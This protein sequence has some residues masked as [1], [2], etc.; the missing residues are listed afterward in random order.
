VNAV[1]VVRGGGDYLSEYLTDLG[2]AE[3]FEDIQP[4][5]MPSPEGCNSVAQLQ[6]HADKNRQDTY[7]ANRRKLMLSESTLIKDHLEQAAQ[8][9]EVVANRSTFSPSG[10]HQRNGYSRR[11]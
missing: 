8:I 11:H 7:W 1:Y 10:A 2:P 6:E 5:I 3:N 9:R 4:L